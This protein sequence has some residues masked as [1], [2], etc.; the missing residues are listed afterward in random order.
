[1][2]VEASEPYDWEDDEPL[3]EAGVP[4]DLK[5]NWTGSGWELTLPAVSDQV[6]RALI[7]TEAAE[8]LICERDEAYEVLRR[9]TEKQPINEGGT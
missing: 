1:M 5:A 7:G 8:H 6:L 9:S 4:V 2:A 3:V